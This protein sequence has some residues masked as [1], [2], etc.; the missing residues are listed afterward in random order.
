M[1]QFGYLYIVRF[2]KMEKNSMAWLFVRALGVYFSAQ[3]IINLYSLIVMFYSI[4]TLYEL[5][6]KFEEA[7]AEV[8]RT[9]VQIGVLS[10]EFLIFIFLA[11]YCL[12]KGQFIHNLIMYRGHNEKT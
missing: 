9:W 1:S 6:E 12:R 2:I 5:S 3:V 11:F 10:L 8:V 4:Q 7:S